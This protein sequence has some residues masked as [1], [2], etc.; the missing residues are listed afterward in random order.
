MIRP[1]HHDPALLAEGHGYCP[2]MSHPV[3]I[4]ERMFASGDARWRDSQTVRMPKVPLKA[5][6]DVVERLARAEWW[7]GLVELV[8]NGLD[9]EAT[10][11]AVEVV[12]GGLLADEGVSEIVVRDDGLGFTRDEAER[13]FGQLG[14]SWKA[15]APGRLTQNRKFQLHGEKGQGRFK[16]FALGDGVRWDSVA[17][18][19]VEG[20]QRT[21]V[22]IS[23]SDFVN[24][25]VPDDAD[26]TTE[27]T[28]TTV[29][30]Y[31]PTPKA[32]AL[33]DTE[34]VVAKLSEL[35]ALHLRRSPQIEVSVDGVTVDPAKAIDHEASYELE[36]PEFAGETIEIDVIEWKQKAEPR[37]IYLC[38]TDGM[39]F[40]EVPASDIRAPGFHFSAYL[41]W[42]KL[43]EREHELALA[44]MNDLRPVLEAA[45]A[46]LRVHFAQR[47]EELRTS[48]IERWKQEN[49][50]PYS[51]EP[52]DDVEAVRRELFEIVAV[53]VND[54][55]PGLAKADTGTRK[56]TL[57]LLRETVEK[58]PEHLHEILMEITKLSKQELAEFA[59]LLRHTSLPRIIAASRTIIDRLQ[60]LESLSIL[61]FEHTDELKERSQLHKIL[62]NE[63][64]IF[65][66]HYTNALSE[67]GLTAVLKEFVSLLGRDDLAITEPVRMPDGSL[68]RVDLMLSASIRGAAHRQTE[69][70]VVE[71]KA[72]DVV[73]GNSEYDQIR[74]Y[75]QR[76]TSHPAVRG[77]NAKWDFWLIGN[78]LNHDE[79]YDIT[80][81]RNLPEGCA[82]QGPNYTVWIFTW[83]EVIDDTRR[84]LAF[85]QELV[86]HRPGDEE[87]IA[88]LH[89]HHQGL[90]PASLTDGD[91]TTGA[92]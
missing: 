4:L 51:G 77:T 19:E 58:S 92:G 27:P 68:R 87:A 5:K 48:V 70:L 2:T 75:A 73:L 86:D 26:T 29:T 57:R 18:H 85:L 34:A 45:K 9:A 36:V 76:V 88:Y 12:R 78:E 52:Q 61:L 6:R 91:G 62:E 71:L 44:E 31:N 38:D 49:S 79:L 59:G 14:G 7:N 20:R 47:F 83:A 1:R 15:T 84:R 53:S 90:L 54:A 74:S 30:V 8:W 55:Q 80:H 32:L 25:A 37:F 64:W 66:D 69:H 67:R 35:L 24:A 43:R 10:H 65:G 13:V 46:R 63:L 17:D 28:G 50:Y 60:F 39:S 56:L 72:P 22:E 16:A 33:L 21:V 42:S 82:L 41:R 11:V 40:A 81:Q 3:L 89:R 23:R